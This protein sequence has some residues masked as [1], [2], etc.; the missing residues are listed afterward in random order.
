MCEKK[1]RTCLAYTR[2]TILSMKNDHNEIKLYTSISTLKGFLA[3]TYFK[4]ERHYY[5]HN[6]L[7]NNCSILFSC[8]LCS[9]DF[10]NSE[11]TEKCD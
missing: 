9:N 3:P 8:S 11:C 10:L 4:F 1:E 2:S 5:L 7:L 6:N